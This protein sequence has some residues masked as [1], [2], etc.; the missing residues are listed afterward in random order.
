MKEKIQKIANRIDES[1]KSFWTTYIVL[2][3]FFFLC[4]WFGFL[5]HGKGFIWSVDGLEQQY[6]F[7]I[8]QGEWF[9][10]L[11][12]NV[13][14]AHTFEIPMWTPDVGYGADYFISIS[15][16]FGNPINWIS[17]FA[18]AETADYFLNATV[19]LTLFLAGIAF[20]KFCLYE[21]L[22][23]AILHYGCIGLSFRRF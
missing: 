14:V 23:I 5:I 2:F 7:F 8:L 13:F 17:V 15:N 22:M 1:N 20:L 6:M 11:L 21:G 16:T 10:D 4:F 19:P 9:R 12:S 18:T 3:A